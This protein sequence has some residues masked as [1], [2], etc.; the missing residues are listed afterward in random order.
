MRKIGKNASVEEFSSLAHLAVIFGR[1]TLLI[2]DIPSRFA[3]STIE[4]T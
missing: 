1:E 3:A 2:A 4:K